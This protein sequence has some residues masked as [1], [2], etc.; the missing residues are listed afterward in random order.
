MDNENSV[1]LFNFVLSLAVISA[2]RTP[3]SILLC[4]S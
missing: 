3:Y 2:P 1:H 4:P